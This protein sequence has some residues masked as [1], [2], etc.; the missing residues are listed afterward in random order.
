MLKRLAMSLGLFMSV[1]C[2]QSAQAPKY[3]GGGQQ[4]SSTKIP[5]GQEGMDGTASEGGAAEPGTHRQRLLPRA[6]QSQE[7]Q[8][9]GA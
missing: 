1:G 4:G 7:V 9:P 3:Q 6:V 5:G 2:S 8:R